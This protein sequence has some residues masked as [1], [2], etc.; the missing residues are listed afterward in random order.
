MMMAEEAKASCV[1]ARILDAAK[2]VFMEKDI[3][4]PT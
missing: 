3:P 4:M 1:E 2:A